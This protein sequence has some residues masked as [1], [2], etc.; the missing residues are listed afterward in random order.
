VTLKRATL[1][2]PLTLGDEF[3]IQAMM[4]NAMPEERNANFLSRTNTAYVPEVVINTAE[5]EKTYRLLL[6]FR[7]Q[8]GTLRVAG[9]EDASWYSP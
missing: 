4:P 8:T 7:P 3:T 1:N 5:G 2:A 9:I 6:Q